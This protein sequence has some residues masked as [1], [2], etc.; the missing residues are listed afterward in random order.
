MLIEIIEKY[1]FIE[2]ISKDVYNYRDAS[3]L[4][5]EIN[6]KNKMAGKASVKSQSNG[7]RITMGSFPA[8]DRAKKVKFNIEAIFPGK[9]VTFNMEHVRKDYT[10]TKIFAGPYNSKSATKEVLKE[11]SATLS[12]SLMPHIHQPERLTLFNCPASK[13]NFTMELSICL[14]SIQYLLQNR[15]DSL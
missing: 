12:G 8:L 9:N 6:V 7:Y 3:E 13:R 15:V 1:D 5:H 4:A 11:C 2:L 10:T 14:S